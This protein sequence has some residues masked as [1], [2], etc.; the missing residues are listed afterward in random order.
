MPDV[1]SVNADTARAN[2]GKLEMINYK[3]TENVGCAVDVTM[4]FFELY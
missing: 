3:L 1:K 4:V 2:H